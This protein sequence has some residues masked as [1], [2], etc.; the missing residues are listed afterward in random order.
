[1]GTGAAVAVA[2]G[3]LAAC[4]VMMGGGGGGIATVAITVPVIAGARMGVLTEADLLLF[5]FFGDAS[6][7]MPSPITPPL[8]PNPPISI[9]LILS[10]RLP[11][12]CET[13][14][15][16]LLPASLLPLLLPPGLKRGE[17][18][19]A[20]EE[21]SAVAA[22]SLP[23]EIE[24]NAFELVPFFGDPDGVR[25]LAVPIRGVVCVDAA[26]VRFL[27]GTC[28]ARGVIPYS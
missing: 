6:V 4:M 24:L 21:A 2:L 19:A 5:L 18:E 7:M 22:E 26:G 10:E 9:A 28:F 25:F 17:V 14:P 12:S 13:L 20:R 1:M 27:A 3:K 8:A 23:E 15:D 11:R 16:R